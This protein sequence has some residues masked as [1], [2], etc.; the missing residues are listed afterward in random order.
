MAQGAAMADERREKGNFARKKPLAS[1]R[2]GSAEGF[3]DRGKEEW[4]MNQTRVAVIS[5]IVEDQEAAESINRLLH[6]YR[7][8]IIGRMGLPYEKKQ[9]SIISIATDGPMDEISALSGKLGALEGVS[10]KTIYSKI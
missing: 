4:D 6:Q 9:I 8:Y 5:I 10:T 1:P 2:K 7:R 3:F